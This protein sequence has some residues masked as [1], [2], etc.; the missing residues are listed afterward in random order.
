MHP[1]IPEIHTEI[2]VYARGGVIKHIK[3]LAI[4]KVGLTDFENIVRMTMRNTVHTV[5]AV[6]CLSSCL[7]QGS[8]YHYIT[9]HKYFTK[10][11]ILP[12]HVFF[13]SQG[14]LRMSRDQFKFL[15]IPDWR[16]SSINDK[17]Q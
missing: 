14:N 6:L 17:I 5:L 3:A 12:C 4:I 8:E 9:A 10:S 1:H 13:L 16:Q 15:Q 11:V 2:V 7:Q